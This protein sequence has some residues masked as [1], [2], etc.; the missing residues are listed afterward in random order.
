[1]ETMNIYAETGS[2]VRFSFPDNGYEGD[3][4][5]AAKYLTPLNVY[6]VLYTN[7]G[8]SHTSVRLAEFPDQY[9]N[10]VQFE[11]VI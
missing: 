9:F 1:M 11:D 10:S 3:R 7:V 8:N 6:T 5:H 2:R 4:V